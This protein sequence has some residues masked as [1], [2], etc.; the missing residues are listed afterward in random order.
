MVLV[1]GYPSKDVTVPDIS[2]KPLDAI[3]TWI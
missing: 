3:S 2:K 1:A